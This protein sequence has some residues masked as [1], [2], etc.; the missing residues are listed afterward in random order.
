MP[1]LCTNLIVDWNAISAVATA[2]GTLVALGTALYAMRLDLL[3]KRDID[4]QQKQLVSTLAVVFDHE[5]HMASNLLRNIASL[6]GEQ[7]DAQVAMLHIIEGTKRIQ[8]PLLE[9][10]ADRFSDFEHATAA[11]LAVALSKLL[12]QRLN[13]PPDIETLGE[14]PIEAISRTVKHSISGAIDIAKYVEDARSAISSDAA[15]IMK[16]TSTKIDPP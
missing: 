8:F 16:I 10:F 3:R 6:A 9:R 4:R 12:Q 13:P 11:K 14:I 7:T 15:R 5:L 1:W 2:V